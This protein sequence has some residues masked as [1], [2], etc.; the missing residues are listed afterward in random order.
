MLEATVDRTHEKCEQSWRLDKQSYAAAVVAAYEE[1][2]SGILEWLLPE[3]RGTNNAP[4][5]T[6]MFHCLRPP[7]PRLVDFHH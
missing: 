6:G 4:R 2:N 7:V 3:S 5:A 1:T